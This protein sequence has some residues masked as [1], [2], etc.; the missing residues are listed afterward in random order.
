[1]DRRWY[2]TSLRV[3]A[4]PAPEAPE[5]AGPHWLTSDL[6]GDQHEGPGWRVEEGPIGLGAYHLEGRSVQ[7]ARG[8]RP[9]HGADPQERPPQPALVRGARPDPADR[10]RRRHHGQ[11]PGEPAVRRARLTV[12]TGGRVGD[13]LRRLPDGD[14]VSLTERPPV[15]RDER[16]E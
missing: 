14:P 2:P 8:K 1:M 16:R 15:L 13:D 10:R 4:R 3:P 11:L 7:I 12:G 5:P 9:L 6:D